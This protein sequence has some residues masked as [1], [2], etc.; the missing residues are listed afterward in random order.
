MRK[1]H[2]GGGPVGRGRHRRCRCAH[3]L[4]A[5]KSDLNRPT[6]VAVDDASGDI[7]IADANNNV[8]EKSTPAGSCVVAG[9][10]G[11]YGEPTPAAATNFDLYDPTGVV[12]DASGDLYI[13]DHN[14]H[15][16]E[17]VGSGLAIPAPPPPGKTP[18]VKGT[19]TTTTLI[20][21]VVPQSPVNYGTVSISPPR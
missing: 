3:P 10:P 9:I 2:A 18:P 21:A 8:V 14:N 1:G 12:A 19:I 7:Y 17:E 5:T 15:E 20:T 16:V 4:P 13:A 6:G 11:S